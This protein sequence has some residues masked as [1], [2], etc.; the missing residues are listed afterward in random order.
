MRIGVRAVSVA[1]MICV[2]RQF[3]QQVTPK[4]QGHTRHGD[5]GVASGARVV[6][7]VTAEQLVHSEVW[8]DKD[9]RRSRK[10]GMIK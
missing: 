6:I 5:A 9:K 1:T 2:G 10:E 7:V 4:Q 8:C 3:G